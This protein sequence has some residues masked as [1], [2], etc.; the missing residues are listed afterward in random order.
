MS[1]WSWL[2]RKPSTPFFEPL[3]PEPE[4]RPIFTEA[5]RQFVRI[6]L[7]RFEANGLT[8]WSELN[9]DLFVARALIDVFRWRAAD[10]T[11][12]NLQA[13]FL[14]LAGETDSLTW[15]VDD[16]EEQFPP[17]RA[18]DDEAAD[19]ILQQHSQPIFVNASSI[20]LI[21]EGNS[22]EYMVRRF[23]ALGGLDVEGLSQSPISDGLVRLSFIIEGL[24]ERHFEIENRK[25]PDVTPALAEMNR[26]TEMKG[27]GRFIRVP[28]GSSESDTFILANEATRP[29]IIELLELEPD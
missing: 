10:D 3:A 21:N 11:S 17:I 23:A 26:I 1:F 7:D 22:L 24:S 25:R 5:D 6:A 13:L 9:R 8:I 27:L 28:E 15:Y 16:V 20:S 29:K 2:S 12:P 4:Q 18:M 14:V 19:T